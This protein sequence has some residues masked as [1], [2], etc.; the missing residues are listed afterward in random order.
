MEAGLS[1][2]QGLALF[3][4]GVNLLKPAI[5]VATA[6]AALHIIL[7]IFLNTGGGE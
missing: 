3:A 6:V 4:V 2:S 7:D 1:V 5:I